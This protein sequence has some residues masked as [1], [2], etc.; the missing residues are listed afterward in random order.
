MSFILPPWQLLLVILAGWV[1]QQQ[2]QIID[3]QRTEIRASQAV[4]ICPI[5][6]RLDGDLSGT[7]R[8][9]F[10]TVRSASHGIYPDRR[11]VGQFKLEVVFTVQIDGNAQ[12]ASL[13]VGV[14]CGDG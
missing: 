5:L 9:S 1:N 2:Q 6:L 4:L 8:S 14:A 3:F 12:L 10:L 13:G 11:S 7:R